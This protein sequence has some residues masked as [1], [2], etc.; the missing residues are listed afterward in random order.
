[1]MIRQLASLSFLRYMLWSI[2]PVLLGLG[3]TFFFARIEAH[4]GPPAL[5][6]AEADPGTT[7]YPFDSYH[8]KKGLAVLAVVIALFFTS[9]PREIVVLVAAGIHFMSRKFRTQ[10][11]LALVD[12]Q[13]LLIF[14]ALFVVSGAL[15]AT[16]YELDL[17]NWLEGMGLD[18]SRPG[19]EVLLTA[20]LTALMG[21]APAVMLLVKLVPITQAS[22]AQIMGVANSFGGNAIMT[23][24]VANIVVVQQARRQGI[25]VSLGDFA[26]LGIPVTAVALAGL[27]GWALLMGA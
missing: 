16:G 22:V 25:V 18:P 27:I 13:V 1:M 23:A 4:P 9:L 21:N 24:S 19:N 8:T 26:R 14:M 2:P 15:Q 10:D 6:L 11:L 3:A 12:W 5:Q 17:V 7:S 20:G